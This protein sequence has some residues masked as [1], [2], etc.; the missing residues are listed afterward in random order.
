LASTPQLE[1]IPFWG[2][3]ILRGAYERLG[4]QKYKYSKINS[5]SENFMGKIA[6]RRAFAPCSP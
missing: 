3:N 5:I 2:K 1:N 4:E 6:A